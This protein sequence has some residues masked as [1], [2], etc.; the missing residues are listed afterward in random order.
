MAK[1]SLI[2]REK[3]RKI[4]VLKYNEKRIELKSEIK[5]LKFTKEYFKFHAKLQK[6]PRDS[7]KVRLHNRCLLSGRPKAI[8]RNFKLCR[9]LVRELALQG[10]LP[11]VTKSSW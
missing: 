1:K 2:E 7:S 8:F 5:K 11:G 4:L 10:F 6:L 3:K 9:H